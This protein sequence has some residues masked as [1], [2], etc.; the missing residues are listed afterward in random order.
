MNSHHL[1]IYLRA[2]LIA[3]I[4]SISIIGVINYVIDPYG[5][6]QVAEISGL[7]QQKEG[8]RS[9][10]RYVKA[11]ELPIRKPRTI[12]IGSS[13][14]HDGMN[15]EHPL[16]NDQKYLPV[17]NLGIDMARIHESL[18]YLKYAIRHSQIEQVIIGL[19]LFM[20]NASQKRN[21]NFDSS[22]IN[23]RINFGNYL[24]T[25]ILSADA[26]VD[27]IR[28]VNVSHLNPE[29]KEFLPNGFRP[30]EMVFY[31]V[32]NYAALHYYTNYIFMSSLN[33]QTKYYADMTLDSGVFDDF[34]EILEICIQNKIQIQTYIS[35]AHANLDG[36][37]IAAA[38]KWELMEEWK[39][40]VV[41]IA[42]KHR[43]PLWDF[44]GYNSI[45]T[46]PIHTPMK[47]YWDSSHFTETVS[48]LI[49]KRI[50]DSGSNVPKDFGVR[51]SMANIESHLA[52][53]RKNRERYINDNIVEMRNLREQYTLFLNGGAMDTTRIEGMF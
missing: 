18:G 29:R 48:D 31:K 49:L 17:Y 24:S 35:P 7:N 21:Y 32:K 4:F 12:I 38:G 53:T 37:G 45:T 51:L 41:F 13:R 3:G 33:S 52:D 23:S 50:L 20:F 43:V 39:R 40:K 36:E 16:L 9:K 30:G 46:E 25:S 8:V 22:L 34:D 42:D 47:Y 28:T 26:L 10:I 2:C 15:P 1:K 44:S 11:L 27:S 19:D 6:Y 5:F 14:V